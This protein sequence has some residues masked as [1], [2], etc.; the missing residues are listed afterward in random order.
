[1]SDRPYV[2]SVD[3]DPNF[4]D[5]IRAALE[6]DCRVIGAGNGREALD[7][8]ATQVPDLVILDVDMPEMDGYVTCRAIRESGGRTDLPILFLSAK[9]RIED[10]LAGLDAGGDD[11]LTKPFHL[12]LLLARVKHLLALAEQRKNLQASLSYATSTAMT[13]MSGMGELGRL[14]EALK[15]FNTCNTFESLLTTVVTALSSFDLQGIVQ[16]HHAEISLIETSRGPASPLDVSIISQIASMERIVH[17]KSRMAINYPA[18]SLLV[19]NVPADESV[20]GRLRDHLAMLAEAADVRVCAIASMNAAT[21]RGEVIAR[22]IDRITTALER[23]DAGQR[24]SRVAT[25]IAIDAAIGASET[26][27]Q[28]MALSEAQEERLAATI[29]QGLEHVTEVQA[30]SIDI[31]NDLSNLI[32]ELKAVL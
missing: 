5:I 14:L 27:L 21:R 23:I 1:M 4:Q 11:Y 22:M 9:D 15:A 8:I 31:Q 29:R 32:A 3:D 24:N 6:P 2:I 28:S 16:I 30:S 18:L 25:S 10:R 20:A 13:A 7:L 17:F 19:T 26:A 12:E